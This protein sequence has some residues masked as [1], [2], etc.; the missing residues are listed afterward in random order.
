MK[1]LR[2]HT[3]ILHAHM[4]QAL[5]MPS[6]TQVKKIL[7]GGGKKGRSLHHRMNEPASQEQAHVNLIWKYVGAAVNLLVNY[8]SSPVRHDL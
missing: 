3:H 1:S 5:F 6:I 7:E 4:C 2:A 8:S